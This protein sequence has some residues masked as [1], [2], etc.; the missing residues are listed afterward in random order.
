MAVREDP[1][2]WLHAEGAQGDV[3]DGIRALVGA[4]PPADR[5]PLLWATCPRGDWLLGLATRL[6]APRVALVRG[7][8]GCARIAVTEDDARADPLLRNG[9][10]LLALAD[11]WTEGNATDDALRAATA[12]L[13]AAAG[14]ATSPATDA[15][16]RAVLAVGMGLD[17]RDVL[18][19]AA[20]FA[21]ESMM[22]AT[23]DCGMPLVMSYAHGK[24]A[25]AVR[26]A[27]PWAV[28]KALLDGGDTSRV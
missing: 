25:D 3:I 12:A 1:I 18:A 22:M 4:A 17:D 5:W 19:G 27:V 2:T 6:G 13:E 21:A 24:C 16:V 23:L 9:L 14:G 28:A 20:A 15:A 26:A 8:I 10:D 11:R 7:A